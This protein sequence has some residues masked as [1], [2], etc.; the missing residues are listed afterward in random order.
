[1]VL[2]GVLTKEILAIEP[3]IAHVLPYTEESVADPFAPFHR[4]S[5]S[6]DSENYRARLLGFSQFNPHPPARGRYYRFTYGRVRSG[7]IG[8]NRTYSPDACRHE[9][10]FTRNLWYFHKRVILEKYSFLKNPR[11]KT[12]YVYVLAVGCVCNREMIYRIHQ[13]VMPRAGLGVQQALGN[14]C[15]ERYCNEQEI[16]RLV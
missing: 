2:S 8:E 12:I 7:A 10:V 1:M 13:G 9:D 16:A 6:S 3:Y 4:F 15:L 5:I 11:P 14:D